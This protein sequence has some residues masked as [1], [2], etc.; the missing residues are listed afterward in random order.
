MRCSMEESPARTSVYYTAST[1]R[2]EQASPGD[3][4]RRCSGKTGI[5]K[6]GEGLRPGHPSVSKAESGCRSA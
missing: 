1:N 5:E 2:Q 6:K 4:M 3:R